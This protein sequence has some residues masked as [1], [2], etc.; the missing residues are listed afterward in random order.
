M[1]ATI[2]EKRS[3]KMPMKKGAGGRQQNYDPHT[4]RFAKTDFATLLLNLKPTKEERRRKAAISKRG[5]LYNRAKNSKD[6]GVFE[7]F[8]AIEQALPGSVQ[9]VNH[10]ILDSSING[11]REFDIITKKCIIEVKSGSASGCL[12]QFQAQQ[13]FADE[14]GKKHIVLAPRIKTMTKV[15]Y[16][17]HGIKIVKNYESLINTIKEYE[18]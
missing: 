7:T 10:E 8:C 16:E 2:K 13:R 1:H 5:D 11:R 17:N 4:G 9:V 15:D 14:N 6:L 12:R 3:E 18:K